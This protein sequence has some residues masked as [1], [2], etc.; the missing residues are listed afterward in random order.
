MSP[1]HLPDSQTVKEI[2]IYIYQK[3]V[4]LSLNGSGGMFHKLF[5]ARN[6]NNMLLEPI[7]DCLNTY[8]AKIVSPC[9]HQ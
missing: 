8:S 9:N 4:D 2:T 5:V 7:G 6:Y 1:N 3:N